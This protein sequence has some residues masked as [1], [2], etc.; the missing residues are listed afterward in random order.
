MGSSDST[1]A[2]S[3]LTPALLLCCRLVCQRRRLRLDLG[4][5]PDLQPAVCRLGQ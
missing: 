2:C 5:Q 3:C 1:G 4:R